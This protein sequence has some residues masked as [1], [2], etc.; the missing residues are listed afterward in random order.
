MQPGAHLIDAAAPTHQQRQRHH[1]DQLLRAAEHFHDTDRLLVEQVYR[2]GLRVSDIARLSDQ[3]P[4]GLRRRLR[5]LV[6]RARDPL[7]R[8]VAGRWDMIPPD[9]QPVAKRVVLQGWSLRDAARLTGRT[10][11]EVRQDMQAVHTLFR[12]H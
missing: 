5:R 7:F 3:E 2:H 1:N 10:L 6:A 11:H 9:A 8:F 4:R 12:V